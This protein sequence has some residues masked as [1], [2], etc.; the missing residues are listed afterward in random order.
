M[1]G[2]VLVPVDIFSLP[3]E[4]EMFAKPFALDPKK[5]DVTNVFI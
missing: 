3:D 4:D 5:T 1:G 2:R